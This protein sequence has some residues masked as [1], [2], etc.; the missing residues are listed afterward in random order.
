[1]ARRPT[2]RDVARRAYCSVSAASNILH[3]RTDLYSEE[4][5]RRVL[6]AAQ[7]LGYHPVRMTRVRPQTRTYLLALV[8]DR[9]HPPPTRNPFAHHVLDGILATLEPLGYN[10]TLW[11]TTAVEKEVMW[12]RLTESDIEGALLLAPEIDS[13]LLHWRVGCP[14]PAVVVGATLPPSYGL[15]CVDVDNMAGMRALVHWI[16]E[17]GHRAIGYVGGNPRHWSAQQREQA[18]RE[19]LAECGVTLHEQWLIEGRYS[20]DSGREAARKLLQLEARPTAVICAN[21]LM[22]IGLIQELQQRGVRVPEDISIAGF[23]DEPLVQ[24]MGYGLTT[25]RSPMHA[26]GREATTLLLRILEQNLPPPTNP[27]L[28]PGVLIVRGSVRPCHAPSPEP[29]QEF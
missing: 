22:A 24:Q 16:V 14:K 17:Q 28:L 8:L 15:P 29:K 7:E 20:I 13:P 4:L 1:M 3:G 25:I 9:Y 26:L 12:R 23:D 27:L 19:A 2:L 5:V 10:L 21:D 6:Q 18:F 11:M